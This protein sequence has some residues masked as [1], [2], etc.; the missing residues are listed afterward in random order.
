MSTSFGRVAGRTAGRSWPDLSQWAQPDRQCA[1]TGSGPCAP[2]PLCTPTRRRQTHGDGSDLS[3][4]DRLN[5]VR[6]LRLL[7]NVDPGA[8]VRV[9]V[10]DGRAA[11]ALSLV[12]RLP[13][14]SEHLC[15]V[16]AT[17]QR[18]VAGSG[19]LAGNG[20]APGGRTFYSSWS[21]AGRLGCCRGVTCVV[22]GTRSAR[23]QA[24]GRSVI[25]LGSES[26]G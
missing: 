8:G 9:P 18:P 6:A 3:G 5:D 20:I 25:R 17:S 11:A 15:E 4:P 1:W 16:L 19:V 7:H 10:L 14:A 23:A 12:P 22:E 21:D 24:S 13:S 2:P 26:K